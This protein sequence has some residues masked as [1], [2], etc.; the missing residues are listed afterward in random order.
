MY[1]R[2]YEGPRR[3]NQTHFRFFTTSLLSLVIYKGVIQNKGRRGGGGGDLEIR[4]LVGSDSGGHTECIMLIL[5]DKE[6]KNILNLV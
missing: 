1:I 5:I 6:I 2:V 4:R 3:G